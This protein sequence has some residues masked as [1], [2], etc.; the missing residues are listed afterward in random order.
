MK[1]EDLE[2]VEKFVRNELLSQLL[3][4]YERRKAVFTDDDKEHFFGMYVNSVEEFKLMRGD[5]HLLMEIAAHLNRLYDEKGQKSFAEHFELP[6]NYKIG[7]NDTD[8]FP[9]GIFYG[10]KQRSITRKIQHT[11]DNEQLID[12]LFSKLAILFESYTNIKVFHSLNKNSIKIVESKNGSVRADVICVFCET[13]DCETEA[14]TKRI[15]VQCDETGCW[16]FS[17]LK[18]HVKTQH[19]K[20]SSKLDGNATQPLK[21]SPTK[22][23]Q[24]SHQNV[25]DIQKIQNPNNSKF[26]HVLQSPMNPGSGSLQLTNALQASTSGLCKSSF[27]TPTKQNESD[28]MSMPIVIAETPVI[29]VEKSEREKKIRS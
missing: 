25:D 29:D 21:Q 6:P 23:N 3:N 24:S 22:Q 1:D 27:K 9:C 13:N 8:R 28:I 26:K 4:K 18:K 10:K 11:K 17:N 19:I 15:A 16:N 7:K 12:E 14:L 20:K 2:F 5:R